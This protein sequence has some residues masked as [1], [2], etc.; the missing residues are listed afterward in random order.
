MLCIGLGMIL[1]GRLR[2]SEDMR[3]FLRSSLA[4]PVYPAM[5]LVFLAIGVLTVVMNV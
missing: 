3:P 1:L 4:S 2:K 5:I